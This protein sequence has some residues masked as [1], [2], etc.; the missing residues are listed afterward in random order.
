MKKVADFRVGARVRGFTLVELMV[1]VAVMAILS[2]IAYP[3]YT[4]QVQKVRRTDARVALA[5]IASA[6]ERFY[7]INGAYTANLA[8]LDIDP[9]LQ[10][11]ASAEDYYDL[12][13]ALTPNGYRLTATPDPGKS[14]ADDAYCTSLTLDSAGTKDGTGSDPDKCW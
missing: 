6:Q 13:V 1:A 3:L 5:T 8:D 10:A 7:S 2:A 12:A 14:Q 9:A 4:S 11:G